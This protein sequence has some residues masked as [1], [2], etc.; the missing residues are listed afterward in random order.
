MCFLMVLVHS[1]LFNL[2]CGDLSRRLSLCI[3]VGVFVLRTAGDMPFS[4][5]P[6][7]SYFNS[8]KVLTKRFFLMSTLHVRNY[9][10]FN[11]IF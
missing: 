4:G 2:E 11:Q 9:F 10:T 1:S 7:F 3:A 5:Y 8:Y 6:F